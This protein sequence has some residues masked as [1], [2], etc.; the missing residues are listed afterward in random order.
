M[1]LELLLTWMSHIGSGS[2]T[3]FKQAIE[4][5]SSSD[6]ESG[7]ARDARTVLS[8]LGFADFFVEGTRSWRMLPS[9]IGGLSGRSS[10]ILVG[11]RNPDLIERVRSVASRRGVEVELREQG[12]GPTHVALT[13]S[14]VEAGQLAEEIGAAWTPS[15]ASEAISG[16]QGVSHLMS[17]PLVEPPK[18]WSV[19]SFDVESQEWREELLPNAA[20]EFTSRFG[21]RRFFVHLKKGRFIT[22]G[23]RES[24]YLGAAIRNVELAGYEDRVLSTTI[25]A[26]LPELLSRAAC[27]CSGRM[28]KVIGERIRYEEVPPQIA[29]AILAALGQKAP[30]PA[31]LES[32]N[33]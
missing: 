31:L 4:E 12:G 28:S 22:A 32:R 23:K 29:G 8:N 6:A 16:F 7:D 10:F 30:E 17:Q 14:A 27:C 15:L 24:I 18:N 21:E 11:G 5:I 3:S 1:N 33:G 25:R 2:W 13:C 9:R 26:P 19:S 20:C